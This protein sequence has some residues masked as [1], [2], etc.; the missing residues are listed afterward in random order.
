MA[1]TKNH[2]VTLAQS[3]VAIVLAAI[4]YLVLLFVQQRFGDRLVYRERFFGNWTQYLCV[5]LAFWSLCILFAKWRRSARR[6]RCVANSP[7]PQ[8]GSLDTDDATRNVIAEFQQAGARCGDDLMA[9][10][11]ER[12]IDEFRF[13]REPTAV[14]AVLS[15]ESEVAQADLDSAYTPVR[16]F[17]WTIPVLGF[18]GTIV[19]LGQATGRFAT[20]LATGTQDADQVRIALTRATT[21]LAFAF[22]TTL[23]AVLL[24][25]IVTVTYLLLQNSEKAVL[26]TVDDMCRSRLLPLMRPAISLVDTGERPPQP[27]VEVTQVPNEDFARRLNS[28]EQSILGQ[29]EALETV[30]KYVR[31]VTEKS[32]AP[33]PISPEHN[34]HAIGSGT[35]FQEVGVQRSVTASAMPATDGLQVPLEDLRET[36]REVNPVL[37]RLAE[38]LRQQAEEA[39][40]PISVKIHPGEERTIG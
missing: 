36:I 28:A 23:V 35:G 24:A 9:R 10:R 8:P 3:T 26:R 25:L 11:V 38:H 7:A 20:F 27:T 21:D 4:S 32:N 17:A 14:A 34:G 5:L 22:E 29:C 18:I 40:Y 19:A 2:R 16:I 33:H 15:S 13:S 12:L 1:Q 39:S 30:L 37:R 6:A 31:E